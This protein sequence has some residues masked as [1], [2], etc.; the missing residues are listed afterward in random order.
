MSIPL[1]EL[2]E[3]HAG[4]VEGLSCTDER[5]YLRLVVMFLLISTNNVGFLEEGRNCIST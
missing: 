1:R 5:F 3:R 4:G 2:I